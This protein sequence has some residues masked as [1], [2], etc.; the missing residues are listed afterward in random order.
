MHIDSLY[1]YRKPTKA[2]LETAE[3]VAAVHA[4]STA[5]MIDL[6]TISLHRGLDDSVAPV[7]NR[8]TSTLSRYA[9]TNVLLSDVSQDYNNSVA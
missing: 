8:S 3:Y 5:Q 6:D 2:T 7:M 4:H 1:S 9:Q